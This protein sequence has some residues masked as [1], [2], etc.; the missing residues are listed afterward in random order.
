MS[1]PASAQPDR[2]P[3]APRP[4]STRPWRVIVASVAGSLVGVAIACVVALALTLNVSDV[5]HNAL[6][7]DIELEDEADDVRAAILDLRH[8]HRNLVFTGPTRTGMA[9]FEAAFAALLEELD[10]LAAVPV[11]HPSLP[12]AEDLRTLAQAYFATFRPAIAL[13]ASDPAAF[14]AASD[15]GLA[16]LALLQTQ[17]ETLED[18]A[19]AL[20]AEALRDV[21]R[22]TVMANLIMLVVLLGVGAA[23]IGLAVTAIR[24]V[25]ELRT[26]YAAQEATAAALALALRARTD[27]IADA[28]HELRTP[29]TVLRG[30]AELGLADGRGDCEHEAVLREIVAESERMTRLV[31]DLLLLARSDAGALGLETREVD[32][33][34]WLAELASR[35]EILARRRDVELV[36]ELAARARGR[37]DPGRLEQAVMVLVDNAT[38]YSPAGS[39]VRLSAALRRSTLVFEVSDEGPGIPEAAL[40]LVFERFNRGG[41][42]QG[43]RRGGAGLG[44]SIARAIVEGHGG[45]LAAASREGEG[46]RMTLSVPLGSG[47]GTAASAGPGATRRGGSGVGEEPPAPTEGTADGVAPQTAGARKR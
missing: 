46:T 45:T 14:D 41:R 35:G 32:L 28:S 44:L 21:E 8:Y 7:H 31:E 4:L 11:D 47:R 13:H 10:E 1:D 39:R 16:R 20:A 18:I 30:N 6:I 17:A 2:L 38:K 27:F 15:E 26:L 19:E 22:T 25:R 24:V 40:P 36:P 33:E 43:G 42:S 23:G 5:V 34:P 29:L 12:R 37:L 3:V 9:E